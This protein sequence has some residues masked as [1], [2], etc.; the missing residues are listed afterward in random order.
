MTNENNVLIVVWIAL[1]IFSFT[2]WYVAELDNEILVQENQILKAQ[3]Q[4][5]VD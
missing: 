4:R 2:G 1:V 3:L 5:H